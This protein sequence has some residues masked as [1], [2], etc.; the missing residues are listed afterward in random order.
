MR[1][2][3]CLLAV[4]FPA[5]ASSAVAKEKHLIDLMLPGSLNPRPLPPLKTRT[6]HQRRPKNCS[7]AN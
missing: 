7:R 2:V 5:A 1:A 3:V 4:L 6:H